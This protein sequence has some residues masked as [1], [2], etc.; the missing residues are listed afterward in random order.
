M[1]YLQ[2]LKPFVSLARTCTSQKMK[3]LMPTVCMRN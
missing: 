1:N 2:K 3:V